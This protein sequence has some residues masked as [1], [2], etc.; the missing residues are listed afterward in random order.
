MPGYW[1]RWREVPPGTEGASL[2]YSQKVDGCDIEVWTIQ[3]DPVYVPHFKFCPLCGC[4]LLREHKC[5]SQEQ[6]AW[7]Y[8]RYGDWNDN[9]DVPWLPVSHPTKCSDW[10]MDE[11]NPL[12]R[13][14]VETDSLPGDRSAHEFWGWVK[15]AVRGAYA[16]V[17]FR[18]GGFQKIVE[19]KGK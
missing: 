5:R 8:R 17:R 10:H 16:Q 7:H 11:Y 9:C 19:V 6:P 14:W 4:Q 3:I 18:K 12:I 2:C 1:E 13:D 15:D